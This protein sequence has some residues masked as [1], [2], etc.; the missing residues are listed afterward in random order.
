MLTTDTEHKQLLE[1]RFCELKEVRQKMLSRLEDNGIKPTKSGGI[2]GSERFPYCVWIDLP[3]TNSRIAFYEDASIDEE[4]GNFH[5]GRI[6]YVTFF[7][8]LTNNGGACLSA[9]D[10][11]KIRGEV[12]IIYNCGNRYATGIRVEEKNID[13]IITAYKKFIVRSK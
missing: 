11:V 9:N 10:V 12:K 5:P 1:N 4:D 7:K 6:G 8:N 3:E 2:S 13:E